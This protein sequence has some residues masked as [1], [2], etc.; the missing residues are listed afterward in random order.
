MLRRDMAM[1]AIRSIFRSQARSTPLPV[2]HAKEGT[3][4]VGAGE[5]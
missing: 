4:R 1:A 5:R 2:S 3:K